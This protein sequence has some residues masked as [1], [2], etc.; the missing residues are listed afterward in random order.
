M[1]IRTIKPDFYRSQD[2]ADLSRENRLLFVGMWSY[3]D[4]NGV[5]VDDFRLIASDL[6]PLDEDQKE[7]R[8]YVR[9]GLATLARGLLI[10]RYES[11]GK[12]YVYIRSWDRHQRVDRPN[13]ARYPRP[14]HDYNPP[15]SG[16]R[17]TRESDNEESRESRESV[18]TVSPP[19]AVEQRSTKNTP[20]TPQGAKTTRSKKIAVRDDPEFQSFWNVYGNKQAL[21]AAERAWTKA[22]GK[23]GV[24]AD[25]L[26]EKAQ[27]YR[28]RLEAAGKWPEYAALPATWL[29]NERWL[30]ETTSAIKPPV[31]YSG[32][33]VDVARA[34]WQ[35]ADAA[36]AA[37]FARLPYVDPAQRPSDQTPYDRWI[38]EARRNWISEHHTQIVAGLEAARVSA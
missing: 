8:E 3:V 4:D 11:D 25:L 13:K 18:A 15:T 14:S 28:S 34:L 27:S 36:A 24:T 29:N 21:P 37:K 22:H 26:I 17:D 31:N 16:N 38:T 12:A 7:V 19:G 20:P 10:D 2:I 32:D 1:R 9:E 30:D 6:F 5:G 35:A 23:L 33:P